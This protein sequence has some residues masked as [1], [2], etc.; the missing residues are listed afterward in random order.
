MDWLLVAIQWLHVLGG[1]FWFG[2]GLTLT[3]VVLP[4]LARLPLERQRE[5]GLAVNR[6]IGRVIP[7]V[8]I[9]TLV[10]GILRGT[11]FGPVK[12]L[13]ALFGSAYGLTFLVALIATIVAMVVGAKLVGG[14]LEALYANDEAWRPAADG[15]P[16]PAFLAAAQRVR[17]AGYVELAIFL[18]IFT[19][20]IL[21]RFG[22]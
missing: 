4:A 14:S 13:E 2:S 19:A 1:L 15:R 7:P 11:V 3:F 9:T 17:T 22:L 20:M 6:A 10:L 12:S 18:V 21:M 5:V 8:A 16:S